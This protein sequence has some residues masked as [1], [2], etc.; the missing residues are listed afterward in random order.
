MMPK[1]KGSVAKRSLPSDISRMIEEARFPVATTVSAGLTLLYWQIGTRIRVDILAHWRAEYG[2]H[3]LVTLSH[4]L[5]VQSGPGYSASNLPGTATF[6]AAFPT[7]ET[8]ALLGR[9]RQTRS[10]KS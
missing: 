3:I 4:E 9:Q 2:K 6:A 1:R 5:M 8:V 10:V 7:M